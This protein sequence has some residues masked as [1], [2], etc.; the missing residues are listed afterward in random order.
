MLPKLFDSLVESVSDFDLAPA[1]EFLNTNAV[2]DIVSAISSDAADFVLDGLDTLEN[3]VGD[4]EI[5]SGVVTGTL[6][7]AVGEAIP[8][9][10]DGPG[11]LTEAG[12][13]LGDAIGSLSLIDGIV[14]ADLTIDD[15]L[16]EVIDFD[17]ANFAADGLGFLLS[18]AEAELPIANGEIQIETE[19]L[20]GPIDGTIN[21]AGGTLDIDL[22]TPLGDLDISNPFTV[23]DVFE[24]AVPTNFGDLDATV[25]FFNSSFVIPV[26]DMEIEVPLESFTGALELSEGTATL[27]VDTPVG[28]VE[29]DIDLD[30][31]VGDAVV[32][33]LTGVSVE[34]TLADGLV[35][36]LAD[37]GTE[38]FGGGLN[39]G[40]LT[41]LAIATLSDTNGTLNLDSG[42]LSGV[43]SVGTE[44]LEIAETVDELFDL[45]STPLGDLLAL[46]PIA[47]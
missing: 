12:E 39:L 16:Y 18:S 35:D 2:L 14:N 30:D 10:L 43:V 22:V 5:V 21:F 3:A 26:F 19:T 40:A 7:P 11:I 6:L 8:I 9:E 13:I 24:F 4:L 31:L 1:T 23:E 27:V 33:Y 28:P 46:S 34:A 41:E 44:T 25:D 17:L 36:L 38:T 42:L 20:L 47:G 37:S 15:T 29:T 32:D 45:L